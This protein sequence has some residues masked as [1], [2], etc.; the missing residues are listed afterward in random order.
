MSPLIVY[1]LSVKIWL[2]LANT[3]PLVPVATITLF[4][5]SFKISATP[6]VPDEPLDPDVPDEP[7]DPDVPEEPDDPD[8]PDEPLEPDV[9]EVPD[10]PHVPAYTEISD[11][12]V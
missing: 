7:D 3:T 10:D 12:P 2:V 11:V 5:P 4:K 9:P 6:D 1:S 8:V